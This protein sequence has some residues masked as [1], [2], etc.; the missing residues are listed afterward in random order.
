MRVFLRYIHIIIIFFLSHLNQVCFKLD[1]RLN[2]LHV[3]PRLC[4]EWNHM[5]VAVINVLYTDS[6]LQCYHWLVYTDK[7]IP[8]IHPFLNHPINHSL[9]FLFI[10]QF[11]FLIYSCSRLTIHTHFHQFLIIVIPFPFNSHQGGCTLLVNL[12]QNTYSSQ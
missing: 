5:I 9:F 2:Q 10:Q 11:I 3:E 1:S 7:C 4:R 6:H 8:F 12:K